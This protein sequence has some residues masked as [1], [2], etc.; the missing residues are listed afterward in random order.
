MFLVLKKEKKIKKKKKEEE[1]KDKGTS[2]STFKGCHSVLTMKEL[3]RLNNQQ[4]FFDLG[5]R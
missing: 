3:N 1:E 4:L 2:S 5:K